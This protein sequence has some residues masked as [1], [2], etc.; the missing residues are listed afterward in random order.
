MPLL[1]QNTE[2]V[3]FGDLFWCQYGFFCLVYVK[4]ETKRL[5]APLGKEQ[6]RAAILRQVNSYCYLKTSS[7]KHN[8]ETSFVKNEKDKQNQLNSLPSFLFRL[9]VK[10]SQF[11]L[12][13]VKNSN[14]KSQ[15]NNILQSVD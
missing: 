8:C 9:L 10:E 3:L 6:R 12:G 2:G 5:I 7:V 13:S 4:R 14:L 15:S 1:S 11:P